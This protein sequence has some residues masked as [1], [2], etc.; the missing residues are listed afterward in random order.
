MSW[1]KFQQRKNFKDVFPGVDLAGGACYFL[2]DRDYDD[3]CEVTNIS[4][5]IRNTALRPL[6]EHEIFIRN[7]QAVK[8]VNKICNLILAKRL[9]NNQSYFFHNNLLPDNGEIKLIKFNGVGY[10]GF[11]DKEKFSNTDS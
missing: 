6:D 7:N 1:E 2:W 9:I 11:K 5:K 3:D 4:G 10:F 8:I